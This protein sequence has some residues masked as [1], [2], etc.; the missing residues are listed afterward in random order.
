M[1]ARLYLGLYDT[2]RRLLLVYS[3]NFFNSLQVKKVP[4]SAPD[5]IS[6]SLKNKNFQG[7][8]CPQTP[9]RACG[10]MPTDTWLRPTPHFFTI[11]HFTHPP[12]EQFLNEGLYCRE[13]LMAESVNALRGKQIT[14][15][16]LSKALCSKIH[17]L[18]SAKEVYGNL[19]PVYTRQSSLN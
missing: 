13:L 14:P 10:L 4:G 8:A 5:A 7:G 16:L 18:I 12:L 17:E 1:S 19:S 9:P 3:Q 11:T 15:Y 2:W 6:E